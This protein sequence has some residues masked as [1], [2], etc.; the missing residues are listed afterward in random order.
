[1]IAAFS[2]HQAFAQRLKK[3]DEVE[4][5]TFSGWQPG[6]VVEVQRS[7]ILVEYDWAARKNRGTFSRDNVR[8]P[9]EVGALS[10]SRMWRSADGKSEIRAV[11]VER[12]KLTA[13]LR[14]TNMTEI[15]IPIAK[16][17]D[18]DKAFLKSIYYE[19]ADSPGALSLRK[20]AKVEVNRGFDW[21]PGVVVEVKRDR[22]LVQTGKGSFVRTKEYARESIRF[23]FEANALTKA[24]LWM[25]SDESPGFVAVIVKRTSDDVVLRK[26]DMSETTVPRDQLS[27]SDLKYLG[28][29]ATGRKG[30]DA[31]GPIPA[32]LET[33]ND[34]DALMS[35]AI[36]FT[37]Q[38]M[39]T[40]MGSWSPA[41]LPDVLQFS[42]AGLGFSL[43]YPSEKIVSLIPLGGKSEWILVG[44]ADDN[45]PAF[46]KLRGTRRRPSRILWVSL[47]R[48]KVMKQQL[49]PIG[50][51][52]IDYRPQSSSLLTVNRLTAS[53][54]SASES[55]ASESSASALSA[56]PFDASALDA[57][58]L[59]AA[60]K[61]EH[62]AKRS[63]LVPRV[64]LATWKVTP[65]SKVVEPLRRFTMTRQGRGSVRSTWARFV[66]GQS[67]VLRA[68]GLLTLW[69]LTSN[70]IR[71][72][73]RTDSFFGSTPQLT[74]DR[75]QLILPDDD[76][77]GIHDTISGERIAAI[78]VGRT[79][80]IALSDDG[81]KIAAIGEGKISIVDLGTELKE[82]ES[83][84]LPHQSRA[85]SI[86]WIDDENL[87]VGS[88]DFSSCVNVKLK[89][90]IWRYNFSSGLGARLTAMGTLYDVIR[91]KLLYTA[92]PTGAGM[93]RFG[94]D[95]VLAVGAV[96][97]PGPDVL[98]AAE[99]IDL[100]KIILLK[101]GD[102]VRLEV[103]T[104]QDVDAV[105]KM[106]EEQI[107][108][109]GWVIDDAA[110]VTVMAKMY[111]GE[112]ETRHFR[113]VLGHEETTVTFQ[114]HISAIEVLVDNEVQWQVMTRSGSLPS[115][116]TV[117]ENETVQQVADGFS[118]P[119][120]AFFGSV[121]F[122]STLLKR[123]FQY[124]LG[125]TTV[126]NRGLISS[127]PIP[128]D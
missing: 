80:S 53:E 17:S 52:V 33:F 101:K 82:V 89:L 114:P 10:P 112:S 28:D 65:S 111:Q 61:G 127:G 120:S 22:V 19:D 123:K 73:L 9:Y 35:H 1:M 54:S 116:M 107:A 8:F 102:R 36:G 105:R 71:Y 113:S 103:N 21:E 4:V 100:E 14:K 88:G 49:L 122:P 34:K 128:V 77:I 26:F 24:R 13:T 45:A 31:L 51:V 72:S 124:G 11:L 108:K 99:T 104:L 117:K 78:N 67:I 70:S 27:E 76:G 12:T 56:G 3:G 32:K 39:G 119:N 43:A 85:S 110:N 29:L 121:T 37:P 47:A 96:S 46:G 118:S 23:P 94:R 60:L 15:D 63:R 42:Q 83:V 62:E 74:R 58:V 16:L 97:L 30:M 125:A 50:E 2:S 7:R 5:K 115:L 109:A 84:E 38:R 126:S 95:S 64:T 55:S 86:A 6:T 98:E 92:S 87:W 93:S 106:M 68:N 75:K 59:D 18:G 41:P 90:P 79:S 48:R 20:G 81:K 69:D 25:K 57:G 91:G 66:D 40:T 44:L